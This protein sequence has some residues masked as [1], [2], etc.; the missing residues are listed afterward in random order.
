MLYHFKDYQRNLRLQQEELL[1]RRVLNLKSDYVSKTIK[2][3]AQ[4]E[5][6]K[7]TKYSLNGSLVAKCFYLTAQLRRALMETD[8]NGIASDIA[9]EIHAL[10][11]H[12][13]EYP[14]INTNEV[15]LAF[16]SFIYKVKHSICSANSLTKVNNKNQTIVM[17]VD[18]VA[19]A[20][21]SENRVR[22]T[23]DFNPIDLKA[24]VCEVLRANG[25]KVPVN[26][27]STESTNFF[28][29]DG[30]TTFAIGHTP[31]FELFLQHLDCPTGTL[32]FT[33]FIDPS[34][35]LMPR[36]YYSLNERYNKTNLVFDIIEIDLPINFEHLKNRGLFSYENSIDKGLTAS[37]IS[38]AN[39]GINP[40]FDC[41]P[42]L[43]S[44]RQF[45]PS[46]K[47]R[48]SVPALKLLF[49]ESSER[50]TIVIH[51]RNSTY[52]HKSWRDSSNICTLEGEFLF[53]SDS[54]YNVVVFGIYDYV[55]PNQKHIV[56][57]QNLDAID[58]DLQLDI[59]AAACL[60]V[61]SHGGA[62]HLSIITRTPTLVI[63]YT[64]PAAPYVG[65]PFW[66][67]F[68]GCINEEGVNFGPEIFFSDFIKPELTIAPDHIP[69]PLEERG[70]HL[71]PLSH[72]DLRA[73]I[74]IACK[75]L[76]LTCPSSSNLPAT[77]PRNDR[78][79]EIVYNYI[80]THSGSYPI[81]KPESI[82]RPAR[83]EVSWQI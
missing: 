26:H 3:I 60:C 76:G 34:M 4:V 5:F 64:T 43:D 29:I 28:V 18:S 15:E 59:L 79:D 44:T 56:Y 19:D 78:F 82:I 23:N 71:V 52:K 83:R 12:Y 41:Y 81:L 49:P 50:P 9:G 51:L 68:K 13:Y 31:L 73:S 24:F 70:F 6:Y 66:V 61:G 69:H 27:V 36:F 74:E 46:T 75:Y 57:L 67:V 45:S 21:R 10:V 35:T 2:S 7:H 22:N 55:K 25:P 30:Y 32:I 17:L 40:N 42:H 63:D 77:A 1:V 8:T 20:V 72:Y 38:Y 14:F 11:Q 65:T 58:L 62:T 16:E 39:L 53:L 37:Q 80:Q 47:Y 48:S 54:G 33:V